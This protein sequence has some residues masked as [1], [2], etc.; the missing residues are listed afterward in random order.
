LIGNK[1]LNAA[2]SAVTAAVVG[3]I[4]NLAIWFALHVVFARVVVVGA[5]LLALQVPVLGS[6]DWAA[7][8][9]ALIAIVAT[10]RFKVGMIATFAGCSA[11][12]VVCYLVFGVT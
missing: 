10:F 1:S 9:L 12:G 2:L 4:L 8:A 3:V 5:P 6:I 7:L 11:L